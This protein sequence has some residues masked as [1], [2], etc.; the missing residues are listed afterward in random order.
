M[1]GVKFR[2]MLNTPDM[3]THTPDFAKSETSRGTRA[4]LSLGISKGSIV[5]KKSDEE[6]FE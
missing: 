3:V 5:E 2:S 4:G 6:S 1:K